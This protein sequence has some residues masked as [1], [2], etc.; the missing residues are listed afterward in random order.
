MQITFTNSNTINVSHFIAAAACCLLNF[1]ASAEP[2][3]YQ[4]QLSD[5]GAPAN[6]RYDMTFSLADS[7]TGG[8]ALAVDTINN[9][10]V[11]DGLFTVEVDFPS[12]LLNS[13][14]RW[15]SINVEGTILSPRIRLR[16]TPRAQNA[17][18]ANTAGTL[19]FPF[20]GIGSV[21]T[22][23]SI[24][25]TS[26]TG[27]A[28]A[29]FGEI[30]DTSPGGF[31]AGVRGENRG[32]GFTG[33]G[34][35]GSQN[36]FG[37]G[38]YGTTPGG[39]GV[40][41]DSD[42]GFG[43]WGQSELNTGVYA[44]TNSGPQA[45][46]AL[47]NDANTEVFL[48][49]DQYAVL[50]QNIDDPGFGTAI[51]GEGGRV[52]VEGI[53]QSETGFG[54]AQFGIYGHAGSPGLAA[55]SVFGVFGLGQGSESYAGRLIYGV[56]GIAS[57]GHAGNTAYGVYGTAVGSGIP[58]FNKYAGY[59]AG[60]VHV[61]GNLSKSS[62]SFKIDH[63]MDP[64]N[65]YL[66][67][68]F[69]ESPDMMNMYNGVITLDNQGN[70]TVQLPDYFEVLNREFRYQLTA[71]GA[72]MPNLYISSEVSS[73]EF[74]IAGGVAHA[75]VSWEITGIRQD[76]SAIEHPIIVEEDKPDQHR[77]LYLDASA[78]GYDDSRSIHPR[79]KTEH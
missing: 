46:R 10:S 17:V 78:Y 58:G 21:S 68:S 56:Y 77:G 71:M 60:D 31:S 20:S 70:A 74:A 11:T 22:M 25:N 65:K 13:S 62:G 48:A 44:R 47:H 26:S 35:Y 28:S 2:F 3:T 38:V 19:E 15:M 37:Y 39:I 24:Q 34:V 59:F 57:H 54:D 49:S 27:N 43:L 50:G 73:N 64:E 51:R 42:A 4:G 52:G 12:N 79:P 40:Y 18:R 66:S 75:K 1:S 72:P 67:H 29:L 9:V 14:S 45:F 36:G 69:V 8:L 76:P 41:G 23:M 32:T 7:A 30:T 5:N 63:P 6:G 61:T 33:V 53:A 55:S 16:D